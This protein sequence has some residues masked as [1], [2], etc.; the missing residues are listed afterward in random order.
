[1]Q[2]PRIAKPAVRQVRSHECPRPQTV[3][4][5]PRLRLEP[6]ALRH[7]D[8]LRAVYAEAGVR[9]FLITRPASRAEFDRLFDRALRFASSHGMWALVDRGT[10]AVIGRVGFFAFGATGRPELAFLLSERFWGRGLATEAAV[11]SL[12]HGFGQHGWSE[13]VA[14]VRPAN[15]AAI[16]VLMKLGMEAEQRL[17]LGAAA[18]VLYQVS[19]PAFEARVV[20]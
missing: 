20:A 12:R 13:V 17:A 14:L 6:L 10:A 2:V 1:M 9:R 7:A 8:A 5:T 16:R 15:T 19:R 18:A 4:E 3:L 11:A